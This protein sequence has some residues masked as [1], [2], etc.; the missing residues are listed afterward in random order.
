M[1]LLGV[2]QSRGDKFYRWFEEASENNHKAAHLLD[3]LC[4]NFKDPEKISEQI[5]DLEQKGDEISHTIYS[6][7]N[8]TFVTP[9]DREDIIML[10]QSLDDVVDLIYLSA[11]T[12]T[13]YNVKKITPVAHEFAEIITASTKLVAE[14]LPKLRHRRTFSQVHKA[15]IEINRLENKADD[16]LKKSLTELFKNPKDPLEVIRWRDIYGIMEDVTDKTEDIAN[17]LQNLIT[18]YA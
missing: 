7:V 6:E 4:T 10:T 17:V 9:L 14:V 3:K 8:R 15:M 1:N 5:K 18:K 11:S 2:F 16:L 12:I 13:I